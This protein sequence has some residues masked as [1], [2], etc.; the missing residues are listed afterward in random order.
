MKIT[1]IG[2]SKLL[3]SYLY[4]WVLPVIATIFFLVFAGQEK[5]FL[6]RF[7]LWFLLCLAY[8][9]IPMSFEMPKK[10]VY[11]FFLEMKPL[12]II[13]AI[14]QSLALGLGVYGLTIISLSMYFHL[15]E[16]VKYIISVLNALLYLLTMLLEYSLLK[17][18]AQ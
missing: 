14:S 13:V 12:A 17:I 2:I 18:K 4:K 3:V 9:S 6:I 11:Y 10:T 16:T 8:I 15:P 5:S 7:I 1:L